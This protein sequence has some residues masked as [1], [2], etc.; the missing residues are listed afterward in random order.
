MNRI[1]EGEICREQW[2]LYSIGRATTVHI[3]I[4]CIEIEDGRS[5]FLCEA[6][7]SDRKNFDDYNTGGI[8]LFRHVSVAVCEF[9][10]DGA[11]VFRNCEDVK[12]HGASFLD[13]FVDKKLGMRL[14]KSV[15]DGTGADAESEQ[16]LADG[17]TRWY[18]VS[19]R[20]GK[21]PVS[22]KRCIMFSA[23]DITKIIMLDSCRQ[24][25]R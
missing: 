6:E 2:T 10:L 23:R 4:S 15:R 11:P 13:R 25:R 16:R 24:R 7:S 19:V 21:D 1:R 9:T 20:G 22:N 17:W 12:M 14:L 3:A 18:A 5:E 8:E